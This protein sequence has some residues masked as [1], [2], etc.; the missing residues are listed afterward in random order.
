M[1]KN[2][3]FYDII[4][5]YT[6][7]NNSPYISINILVNFLQ[8]NA[9]SSGAPPQLRYWMDNTR[10]KVYAELNRLSNE[11]KCILQGSRQNQQVFLPTFFVEKLETLYFSIDKTKDYAFPCEKNLNANIPAEY[12]REISVDSGMLNYLDN[13]Q[14]TIFPILKLVFKDKFDSILALPT[15]LPR[16]ILEVALLKLKISMQRTR[17]MDF[18]K[19]KLI[20]H[21]PGQ[22]FH[23]KSFFE[24]FTMHQ[25]MSLEEI[26][27]SNDFTFSAWLFLCPLIRTQVMDMVERSNDISSDDIGLYQSVSLILVLNNYYKVSAINKHDKEKAFAAIY[28]KMCE[29]PYLFSFSEMLN[30]TGIGGTLILNHYTEE[31]LTEWLKQKMTV[32]DNKLPD[33]L[34]FSMPND[35]EV[36]VRKSKVFVLCSYMIKDLQ[37]KIKE[38]ITDRWVKLLRD[39]L[40]EKAMENDEYFDSLVT[41]YTRLYAP[42]LLNLLL[43]KKVALLQQEILEE[44]SDSSKIEKFFANGKLIPLRKLLRLK[45]EDLLRD[46]KFMLPFWYSIPIVAILGRVFKYGLNKSKIYF[47]E[48]EKNYKSGYT[49]SLKSSAEKLSKELIPANL[50]IDEYMNTI[51]DRW[52]QIINKSAREKLTR[53]GNSVIKGYMH[54]AV[55]NFGHRALSASMLDE[56]ASRIIISNQAL[57]KISNRNSLHLYIKLYITK[58]LLN[59]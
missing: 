26:E 53:D 28:E 15:H 50:N 49:S 16:R 36:F 47:K 27:V 58:M 34:K 38:E 39:Y 42:A 7:K 12:I 4:R 22:S 45:R 37:S 44:S 40:K 52:N 11:Q 51:L 55:K 23:A 6:L 59:S 41:R 30:F 24:N 14:R 1:T 48:D 43:D 10:E 35:T 31:D 21:F 57:S 8:K 56:L 33:I 25:D 2:L 20:T 13:P 46:S 32:H 5:L 29:A 9:Q 19:Q 17:S 54:D 18:Y 3:D